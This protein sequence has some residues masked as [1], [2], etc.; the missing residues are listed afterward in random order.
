[1]RR[2]FALAAVLVLAA[3][4]LL[5]QPGAASSHEVIVV[6]V[7]GVVTQGTRLHVEDALERAESTGAPLVLHLDTPGGLVDATLEIDGMLANARVPV[8]T[9]VGP[10]G[11]FAASA[12]TFMLLMGQPAG[13]APDTQIGSAQPITSSPTGETQ[14]A[15]EKVENFLVERIRI[16]AERSGR[17]P[18]IAERFITENLNMDEDE[19]L[20]AGVVDL[21]AA[22]VTSFIRS[23]H[24]RE[25]RVLDDTVTL[26]T[27]NARIIEHDKSLLVHTVELLGNPQI[28]FV[29]FLGGLYALIFGLANTGTYV[30]ETIGAL[31][32]L[33]GLVGLG[34]FSTSA[35]G[36]VLILLA[37]VFFV[38][39][40]FT[41]SNGILTVVGVIAL[42]FGAVFL[43]REPLL[44]PDFL[45]QFAI[46]GLISAVATGGV[47]AGALAVALR[48]QQRPVAEGAIGEEATVLEA[49]DPDGRV[50]LRGEVWRATAAGADG[51]I[52]KDTIVQVVAREGL[53]VTVTRPAGA[54]AS[55]DA[56]ADEEE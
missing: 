26:D 22:D 4:P 56:S 11:G 9:F 31:L 51:P 12:G 45:R 5:A 40:V 7:E 28:S 49:L 15:G 36:L 48:A 21:L 27:R 16:I 20:A 41:P 30:P 50:L 17:D 46:V 33:L 24:G 37:A 3:L 53:H 13:M 47:T 23:V 19:A 55:T 6:K 42:A 2:S 10:R 39:E 8:L 44:P 52:P 18:D 29:L 14:E 54:D 34:L 25:A 43:L 32:L 38:A 1:M 35:A